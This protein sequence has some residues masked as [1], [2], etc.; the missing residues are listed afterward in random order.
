MILRYV[1]MKNIGTS[2]RMT[3]VEGE[4]VGDEDARVA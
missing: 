3:S 1:P 2:L 4:A